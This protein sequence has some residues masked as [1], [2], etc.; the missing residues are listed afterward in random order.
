[1]HRA[2]SDDAYTHARFDY[3]RSVFP[4]SVR[5][6]GTNVKLF[7][8]STYRCSILLNYLGSVNRKS[9]F[10][11]PVNLN[12]PMTKGEKFNVAE[13]SLLREFWETT[14]RMLS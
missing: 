13:L 5:K 14:A 10:R 6:T 2:T 12:T 9:E 3:S 1:M 7:N 11:K 4:Q 8:V